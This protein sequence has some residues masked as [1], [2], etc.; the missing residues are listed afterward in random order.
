MTEPIP[1]AGTHDILCDDVSDIHIRDGIFRCT[2]IAFLKSAEQVSP[3]E[4]G[5]LAIPIERL[6]DVIQKFAIA[7]TNAARLAVDRKTFS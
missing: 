3:T 2:L 1:L 7:L 6:P 4:V 5:R